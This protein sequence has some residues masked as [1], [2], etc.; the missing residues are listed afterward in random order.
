MV[1]R[2]LRRAGLDWPV[3]DGSPL[4]GRQGTVAIQVPCRRLGGPPGPAGRQHGGEEAVVMAS[5]RCGSH[6]PGRRR[7]WR[8][9]HPALEAATGDI[10]GVEFTSSRPGNS[11]VLPDLLAQSP[12]E[13]RV[14]TVT[15]DGAYD[16]RTRHA[17]IAGRRCSRV[18][19]G[20][21][22]PDRILT[23]LT[24]D[25]QDWSSQPKRTVPP[26]GPGPGS[27]KPQAASVGRSGRG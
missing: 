8:K 15:A 12:A 13:R 7:P 6:G 9:V 19:R 20:S 21:G 1:G 18:R 24:P 2:L 10:R 27:C 25:P 23:L 17:A 3:P 16:T 22:P 14:G 4:C 11:P 5:G 26:Q